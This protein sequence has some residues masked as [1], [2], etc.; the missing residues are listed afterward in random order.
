[1][2]GCDGSTM[3]DLNMKHQAYVRIRKFEDT[4][5][6]QQPILWA[7]NLYEEKALAGQICSIMLKKFLDEGW[8][9]A[10]GYVKELES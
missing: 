3:G 9:D 7:S 10:F 4:P 1:M 5:N 6:Y 2:L 8:E